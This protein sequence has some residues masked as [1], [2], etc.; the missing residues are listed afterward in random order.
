MMPDDGELRSHPDKLLSTHVDEV[1]E[2]TLKILGRYSPDAERERIISD[3]VSLHDLGKASP[4]FQKYIRDPSS[5]RGARN[6]KAHTPV[7]FTASL[8]LGERQG[9]DSFWKLCVAAAVLGHHSGFPTANRLTDHFLLGDEWARI[10]D[11][12]AAEIPAHEVSE[13]TGFPLEE[14]L[15][16]PNLRGTAYDVAEELIDDLQAK[17]KSD[18]SGAVANRLKM[19]FVFSIL[20]EADKAYLALSPEAREQYRSTPEADLPATL[21]EEHLQDS[22]PSEINALRTS[23]RKQALET[24]HAN[25]NRRLWT[26]ALPTGLGKTL[27]AASLALSLREAS[28]EDRKRR[29][30]LV[31]PFL[32]IIDQT[33]GVYGEFIGKTPPSTLMQS[34]SLSERVYD[35]EDERDA[36]FFLDT[37][38]SEIVITTF[39]QFLLSLLGDR[40][41]H[42]MRFHNLTDAVLIFDE[43]QALPTQLWDIVNHSLTQLT[44]HLGS[45]VILMS[46]TQPGF[47]TEAADL[48]EA[49]AIY[50]DA[51]GRYQLALKHKQSTKLEDFIES[52]LARRPDLEKERVLITLNT[53]ASARTVREALAEDW[54]APVHFL[55]ADVTPKDRLAA[56]RE[57][58]EDE[59]P[60]LVISTQVVEAGVDLDMT[61]VIRDFAPLD[62][63][64]QIAG[65]CN[66]NNRWSR[67]D[68]EIYHLTNQQ[69]RSFAEMVYTV[70]R[71][72]PDVRLEETCRILEGYEIVPEED[73]LGV[74]DDYFDRLRN[75]KDLGSKHTRDWASLADK[76]PNVREL[77]RG[78]NTGQVQLIVAERDE[79]DLTAD[80]E[81]ALEVSDRWDRRRALRQLA[82]RIAQ[83]TVSVWVRKGWHPTDIANPLGH[84]DSDKPLEHPWWIVRPDN[85][86]PETGLNTEGE[87]FL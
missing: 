38:S 80:I 59:G 34:H 54:E 52:I 43:I 75:G 86:N 67:K 65:R 2:A 37:W 14:I 30:F 47:A 17:V 46:A 87:L 71:G 78:D 73:I 9:Q 24:L 83:V 44:Q 1:R 72:S 31:L 74:C 10:I 27:T 70:G 76:Q 64:V 79:E 29:I 13:L 22:K 81:A 39:D 77:L 68:V 4:A 15:T 18:L 56:I 11:R 21:V 48:I 19:Q 8:L 58:K 6:E 40:S 82:G 69:G 26:L 85:Y 7:G 60:C 33:T 63:L 3:I 50:Y 66:R 32:S 41:R 45:T 53:R 57:I 61:L 5:Y 35:T 23:A 62:S 55:T 12:Q 84:Y 20:L 25:P 51:F 16:A 42:Q 36:E 49:P 28:P